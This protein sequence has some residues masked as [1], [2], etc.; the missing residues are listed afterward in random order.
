MRKVK[1]LFTLIE[2]LV[3]VAIFGILVS[4]LAPSL[5]KAR[6]KAK[7]AFCLSNLKQIYVAHMLY[8]GEYNHTFPNKDTHTFPN[9]DTHVSEVMGWSGGNR[10]G[11]YQ[12]PVHLSRRLNYVMDTTR[13]AICPSDMGHGGISW[14][15]T[16]P[17]HKGLGS[18]YWT[19]FTDLMHQGRDVNG[20]D[21]RDQNNGITVISHP[22][23]SRKI[24]DVDLEPSKKI[25]SADSN[26][27]NFNHWANPVTHRHAA[28]ARKRS[29]VLFLDGSVKLFPIAIN[30]GAQML[31]EQ[32]IDHHGYY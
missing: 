31:P 5:I 25:I 27:L 19:P 15:D 23:V 3:V 1:K 17:V 6:N 10:S 9:K 32:S 7:T 20:P 29:T 12:D 28:G 14:S 13:I 26:L 4:I 18:S 2:L 8:L 16:Q 22:T 24:F 11:T 21:D 30:T